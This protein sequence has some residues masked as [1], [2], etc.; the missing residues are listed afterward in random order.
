METG[1]LEEE[2]AMQLATY[3]M[4]QQQ[5]VGENSKSVWQHMLQA[6][7]KP[8]QYLGCQ[9]FHSWFL[10]LADRIWNIQNRKRFLKR[11]S[12]PEIWF[13]LYLTQE[14]NSITLMQVLDS[15]RNFHW[16]TLPERNLHFVN[17][18]SHLIKVTN[19]ERRQCL[20]GPLLINT[21]CIT[22]TILLKI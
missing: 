16:S 5:L 11:K 20:I 21:F 7:T 15:T 1:I 19:F 4:L 14:T 17:Q 22:S 9:P 12:K 3:V 6:K 18:W 8:K 2:K 13:L 10:A